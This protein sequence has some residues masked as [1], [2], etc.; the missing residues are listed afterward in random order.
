MMMHLPI[1]LL[2]R[3]AISRSMPELGLSQLFNIT[4][5]NLQITISNEYDLIIYSQQLKRN[6]LHCLMFLNI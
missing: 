3:G 1:K 2:S 4:I 5:W 6:L